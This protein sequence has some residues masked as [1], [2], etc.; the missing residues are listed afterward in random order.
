MLSLARKSVEF[1]FTSSR[2]FVP[3]S[4][5][6]GFRQHVAARAGRCKRIRI[7]LRNA[8]NVRIL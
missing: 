3:A 7:S 6:D 1:G 2:A 8:I 5:D 4:K